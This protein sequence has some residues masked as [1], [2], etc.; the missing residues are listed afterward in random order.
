MGIELPEALAR[1]PQAITS[2]KHT[3]Y[4][5]KPPYFLGLYLTKNKIPSQDTQISQAGQQ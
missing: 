3:G 4:W 5:V 1:A 2:T